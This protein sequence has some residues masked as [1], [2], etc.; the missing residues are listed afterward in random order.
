MEFPYKRFAL[1]TPAAGGRVYRAK[2][3]ILATLIGPTGSVPHDCLVDPGADDTVFPEAFATQAGIDPTSA[4]TGRASGVGMVGATPR[5]ALVTL[6]V[7]DAAERREWLAWVGFT[8]TPL[9]RPLLGMAGF[10]ELFTATFHGDTERL[11]LAVNS[12]YAGT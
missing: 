8:S 12:R 4:P 2:P 7:A 9:R 5:F 10:L 11:V 1:T 3:I 6:R